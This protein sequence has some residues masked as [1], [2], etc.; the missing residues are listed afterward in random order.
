[1]RNDETELTENLQIIFIQMPLLDARYEDLEN[2]PELE[3]WVIFLRE[4]NEPEKREFLNRLMA[5]SRGIKEAGKILLTISEE[6]RQWVIQESRYKAQMDYESGLLAAKHEGL[7]IA[8]RGMKAKNIPV[9][10]IIEITGLTAEQVEV[11]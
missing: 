8:A 11:L 5:S 2:L 9:E 6:E 1:M 4:G 10:T 7:E 3:K